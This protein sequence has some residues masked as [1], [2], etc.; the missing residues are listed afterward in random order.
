MRRAARRVALRGDDEAFADELFRVASLSD[1]LTDGQDLRD[2]ATEEESD[3]LWVSH[4][5]VT[6]GVVWGHL[7]RVPVRG[8]AGWG[9]VRLDQTVSD[10]TGLF[11]VYVDVRSGTDVSVSA[12]WSEVGPVSYHEEFA[13]TMF[14]SPTLP[15]GLIAR[16]TWSST[17]PIWREARPTS[18]APSTVV[19]YAPGDGSELRRWRHDQ[20]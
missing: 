8:V 15:A 1:D 9:E 19:M 3:E 12:Q 10:P 16:M 18:W 20:E 7:V 2:E 4:F 11:Q 6:Q 5:S 13:V 17:G 14:G